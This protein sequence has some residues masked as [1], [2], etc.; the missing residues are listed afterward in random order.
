M[1]ATLIVV[2]VLLA[3]TIHIAPPAAEVPAIPIAKH[4]ARIPAAALWGIRGRLASR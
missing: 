3:E 1:L 2:A 4:P